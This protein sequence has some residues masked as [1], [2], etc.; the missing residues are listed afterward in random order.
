MEIVL[1]LS[2]EVKSALPSLHARYEMAVRL[3]GIQQCHSFVPISGTKT[4]RKSEDIL[5][6]QLSR[7]TLSRKLLP[8]T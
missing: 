4:D 8:W 1:V 2:N 5:P 6:P 3:P 7:F